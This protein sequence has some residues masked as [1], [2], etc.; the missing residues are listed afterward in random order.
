MVPKARSR[1]ESTGKK[2]VKSIPLNIHRSSRDFCSVWAFTHWV[3]MRNRVRARGYWSKPHFSLPYPWIWDTKS[4]LSH[5]LRLAQCTL[6]V[7]C[8]AAE[9]VMHGDPS[10]LG[11]VL[12]NL[13]INAIDAYK[14]IAGGEIHVEVAE[15]GG[16]LEICVRDH[17]CGIPPENIERI[18][19]EFFSTKPIGEGTGLGL[20]IARDI[21][22]NFFGGV[23]GAESTP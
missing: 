3:K 15:A 7:S 12:T 6:V 16:H 8:T 10:K 22:T 9:P 5:R 2:W 23:I 1:P 18:F 11:Q 21:V 17:G 19:E 4:L 13:I 14:D 20:S